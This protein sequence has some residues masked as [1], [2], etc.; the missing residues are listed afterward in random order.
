MRRCEVFSFVSPVSILKAKLMY[1]FVSVSDL[2]LMI[3][4]YF[5]DSQYEKPLEV[6]I[7][8]SCKLVLLYSTHVSAAQQDLRL[9]GVCG[10]CNALKATQGN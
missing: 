7:R 3:D 6:Q 1:L 8:F 9:L 10:L 2:N 5:A 4:L